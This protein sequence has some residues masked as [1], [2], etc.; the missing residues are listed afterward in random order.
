MCFLLF[1]SVEIYLNNELI[2]H[3]PFGS[4]TFLAQHRNRDGV[5][6]GVANFIRYCFGNMNVGVDAA[7]PGSPVAGWLENRCRDFLNFTGLSGNLGY[8]DGY[9]EVDANMRFLKLG[10]DAATDFGPVGARALAASFGLVLARRPADPLGKLAAAGLASL[11]LTSYTI[12]WM[13]WNARFLMLPF[14]LFA[15]A[16]TLW[17]L[18][19]GDRWPGRLLRSSFFVL[20][21][22]SAVVYPW[23]SAEKRPAALWMAFEHRP[24]YE[25]TENSSLLEVVQ[26]LHDRTPAIGESPLL[27][28]A[29]SNSYLL[30]FFELRGLH[31]VP[32][33][34]VD[35][36][37]LASAS[38]RPGG[39]AESLPVYVL[40]LENPVEP[41]IDP[42]LTLV[43]KYGERDTALY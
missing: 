33:P 39:Q 35:Q 9:G 10:F 30:C 14:V 2:Y 24:A 43:K 40:T 7:N 38:Q 18:Q 19:L 21:V 27:L 6:G 31:V 11:A 13:M 26:D 4:P 42:S 41:G 1:G 17:I 29:G 25:M 16:L 32:A 8:R 3:H 5:A 15:L 37:V 23:Q 22:Y 20:M 12:A 36:Q 28:H 34:I